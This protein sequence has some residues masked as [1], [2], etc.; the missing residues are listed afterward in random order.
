[1]TT[2]EQDTRTIHV[3]RVYIK[4]TPEAIWQAITS[5]DWNGRFGYGIPAEYDLRPGGAMTVHRTEEMIAMG[6][7]EVVVDGEMIEIDPPHRL[8][9]SYR[10]NFMPDQTAE[11]FTTLTYEI[12]PDDKGMTRL[13]VTHDLTDAPIAATMVTGDGPLDQG[14]GGWPWILSSLK[15]LLETGESVVD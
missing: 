8:V 15:T 4:A 2:T 13:T 9:Q 12:E 11:G 14:G 3:Y 1:M 5:T 6:M 10:F 7:P